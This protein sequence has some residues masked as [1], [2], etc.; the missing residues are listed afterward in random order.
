MRLTRGSIPAHPSSAQLMLDRDVD[1]VAR[2]RR[3]I[4]TAQ[5][6]VWGM[7]RAVLVSEEGNYG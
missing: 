6:A 2:I 3:G 4:R 5:G 1:Q 7:N